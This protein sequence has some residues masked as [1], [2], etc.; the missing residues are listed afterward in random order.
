[1]AVTR[2]DGRE[3]LPGTAGSPAPRAD[4]AIPAQRSARPDLPGDEIV[5]ALDLSDEALDQV[6]VAARLAGAEHARLRL[7]A[8]EVLGRSRTTPA[9]PPAD[10]AAVARDR[11]E[12]H[13]AVAAELARAVTPGLEVLIG[14]TA[15]NDVLED[16]PDA[17]TG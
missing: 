12:R 4:P 11:V 7:V 1:M 6:V 15:S 16:L 17:P 5:L 2:D 14:D 9:D 10:G 13:L 8:A 3:L